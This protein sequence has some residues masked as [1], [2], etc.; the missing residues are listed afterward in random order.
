MNELYPIFLRLDKLK[1]LIV[2]GGQVGTEK[3]SLILKNS[4]SAKITLIAPEISKIIRDIALQHEQVILKQKTFDASDLDGMD[5]VIA[6]TNIPELNHKVWATA[7]DR[8]ILT[9]IADTPDLCDFYLG[10]IVTKGDL[11][12]GISTNGKSPTVAKRLRQ[13]FEAVLPDTLDELLQNL[14][15]YRQQLK[16]NFEEKVATLNQLTASLINKNKH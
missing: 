13:L 10:S 7:K 2:G 14:Q 15:T 9:N 12:L 3:M 6:G 8:G 11:K 16:G 5:L 1:L 4:P